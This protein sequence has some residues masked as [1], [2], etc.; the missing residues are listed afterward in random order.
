M[1]KV[2]K[3]KSDPIIDTTSITTAGLV[4]PRMNLWIPSQP[5][6][7]PQI[8]AATCLSAN[9]FT[10]ASVYDLDPASPLDALAVGSGI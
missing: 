5:K 1:T 6:K 7:I 10:S 9:A 2:G 4:S 3:I 8:P